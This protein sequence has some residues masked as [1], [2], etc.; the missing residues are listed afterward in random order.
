M[1]EARIEALGEGHFK[2]TGPLSFETARPL[3]IQS[4]AEF[5]AWRIHSTSSASPA[6]SL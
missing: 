3:L 2:V 5:G 1:S 4:T 6:L